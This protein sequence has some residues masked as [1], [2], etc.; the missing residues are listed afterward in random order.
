MKSFS[1][2]KNPDYVEGWK[3]ARRNE[4]GFEHGTWY[5]V[6]KKSADI[7]RSHYKNNQSFPEQKARRDGWW[8]AKRS[9]D[10]RLITFDD[11]ALICA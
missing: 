2:Y 9:G 1:K 10:R 4:L 6:A 7:D 5:G 11:Y 3:I 8:V